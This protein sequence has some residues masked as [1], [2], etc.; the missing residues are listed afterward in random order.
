M[1]RF[2][3]KGSLLAWNGNLRYSST[4]YSEIQLVQCISISKG[5]KKNKLYIVLVLFATRNSNQ[6][7]TK[8]AILNGISNQKRDNST[9]PA[10][11]T[12]SRAVYSC[13]N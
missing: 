13:A 11:I 10:L 5:L 4:S 9:N 1:E 2:D 3:Y 12:R 8:V 7:Q 6:V